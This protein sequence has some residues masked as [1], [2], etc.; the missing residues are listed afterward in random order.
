MTAFDITAY[1]DRLGL[2]VAPDGIEGVARL[3]EAHIRSIPFENIDALLGRPIATDLPAIANKML[4]ARRGGWCFEQNALLEAALASIDV[5]VERR[6]ARVR[7][8]E[9]AGGPRSHIALVCLL[10]GQRWLVDAG[11]GGPAPLTPLQL[12]SSGRQEA[13]NGTY[14][15]HTDTATNE[16]VIS[17]VGADGNF[18]LYG[19]DEA[20]VTDPDIVAASFVCASWPGSPFPSHLMVNGY[21][22]GTRIG[23]FDRSVTFEQDQRR[24]KVELETAQALGDILIGRLGIA[25][26]D[27]VVDAIWSRVA[28]EEAAA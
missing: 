19:V 23:I 11:F 28:A 22:G 2:E 13:P 10:E 8:G 6:L 20:H 12:D 4:G 14:V 16:R 27:G 26:E 24:E 25:L 1:Q 18:S 7:M 9:D 17:M 3:Q 5:P 15:I 21:D